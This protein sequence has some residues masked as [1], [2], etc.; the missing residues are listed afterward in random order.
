[1]YNKN[2]IGFIGAG[3][4]GQGM[5][6]NLLEAGHE[7]NVIAHRNRR[8]IEELVALGAKE[9]TSL[10]D[11][12]SCC[13]IF[14]LCLPSSQVVM[15]V[16]DVLFPLVLPKTIIIDCTTNQLFTV[17]EL[18][19]QAKFAQLKYVE[20]PLTG[21]QQ[22]S[23][24]AMLGAIV[25]CDIDDFAMV[26]N[27]LKPC[28][29]QIE[30]LG[31][32]GMGATTKLISNFL[33]LGTATLVVEA[34]KVANNLGVDWE[35]FYKLSSQGSGHSMSLDRI[36]PKAISGTHDGYVFTIANTVKD[37]EY[38]SELLSDQ[39]DA[40]AI[41]EVFLRIYKN[42]ANDGRQDALLSSRLETK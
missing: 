28:C 16:C 17:K 27:V 25:G 20:A 21:G 36:A 5:V 6:Q 42:A 15:S 35:K 31:E 26:S 12:A 22:Q 38:I 34:M 40:A 29:S 1:M 37:M 33:A 41:T 32:L 13:N 7:V 2:K 24:D 19:K 10:S 39:P 4:M 14:I 11:M 23:R 3:I 8:P 30:R 18:A 9:M